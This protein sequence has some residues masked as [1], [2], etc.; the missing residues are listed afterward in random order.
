MAAVAGWICVFVAG[1]IIGAGLITALVVS[2]YWN[3]INGKL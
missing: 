1:L 3:F 2:C